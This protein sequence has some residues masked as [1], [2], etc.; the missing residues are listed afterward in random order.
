[1]TYESALELYRRGNY[2]D[3]GRIWESLAP[4]DKPSE[5][6]MRRCVALIKGEMQLENGVYI[7]THK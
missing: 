4:T 2:M 5:I 1:M 3:A 6:M 7:M